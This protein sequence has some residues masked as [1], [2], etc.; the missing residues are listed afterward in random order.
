MYLGQKIQVKILFRIIFILVVLSIN[1]F[2]LIIS[3]GVYSMLVKQVLPIVVICIIVCSLLVY[4]LA[5]SVREKKQEAKIME[6]KYLN[7]M[8]DIRRQYSLYTP[9]NMLSGG[10]GSIHHP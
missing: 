5:R 6:K 7:R 2:G 4:F 9:V 3:M 1:M 8:S 10:N